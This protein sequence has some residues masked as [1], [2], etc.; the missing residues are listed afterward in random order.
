M[1]VANDQSQTAKAEAF[2][3]LDLMNNIPKN[4]MDLIIY[5]NDELEEYNDLML[6]IKSYV[7]EK[8]AHFIAGDESI[9]DGWDAYVSELKN[10]GTDR[11]LELSQTAYERMNDN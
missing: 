4:S 7:T 5:S 9:D 10:M 2:K 8:L 1:V 6:V 3:N 11:A